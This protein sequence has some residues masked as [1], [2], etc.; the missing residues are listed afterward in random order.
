MEAQRPAM[1]ALRIALY[2][3]SSDSA[4]DAPGMAERAGV[5]FPLLHSVDLPEIVHKW[6]IYFDGER[7]FVQPS[8]FIVDDQGR[9]IHL[10]LSSG[11]GGRMTA[12]E[13]LWYIGLTRKRADAGKPLG[14]IHSSGGPAWSE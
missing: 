13:I 6:G 10:M 9:L 8:T 12:A 1:A 4:A 2:G 3:I 14:A 11:T 5:T 7:R